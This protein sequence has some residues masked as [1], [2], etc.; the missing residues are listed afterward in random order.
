MRYV[1]ISATLLLAA[2]GTSSRTRGDKPVSESAKAPEPGSKAAAAEKP[3][4]P[5]APAGEDVTAQM[6][7]LNSSEHAGPP[8]KFRKGHVTPKKAPVTKKTKYGFEIRFASGAPVTTPAVYRGK[9][10]T[11]GGFNSKEFHAF[12]ASTGKSAWSISLDDDGPSSAA[13]EDGLC[14]FN[15]ES[16]T[17]FVVD[18]ETGK[19]QWSVWL[20]DPL[21]GSPTIDNGRV[22]TSYPAQ[23]RTAK[24]AGGKAA[25]PN[26]THAM[27]A[28]DLK[29]GKILWQ[30]WLDSGVMSA[31]VA[32]GKFVYVS[33]FGGTL[34]K[35]DQA[36][37]EIS[38]AIKARAT[39]APVIQF[40]ADGLESMYFTRRGEADGESDGAEEMIMRTDHNHPKTKFKAARKKAKY[41]DK[42]VQEKSTYQDEA[43]ASDS[44]NGFGGAAPAAANPAAA[45]DNIGQ[46][47]VSSMQAFQ[48]SRI[49]HMGDRNV[50][51]MGDEV[52]A[53][54]AETGEKL[55]SF[56]LS[57]DMTRSGGSLGT[58]PLAAGNSV[59][60]ATLD[61]EVKRLDPATGKVSG[62]WKIAGRVRAQP[63]VHDGWIYVG[64]EDGRLVAIDTGDRKVTGWA[65]WGGNAQRSGV[66]PTTKP[67]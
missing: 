17:L 8:T 20:G 33:T 22:F 56:K 55:W 59:V 26:A 32:S 61:G 60:F 66:G 6:Q 15:T 4:E 24:N 13:C 37:G 5:S 49:L 9:V 63:V 28:F 45:Y 10:Y 48:G 34:V 52:I 46:G 27:A 18:A 14:A 1:T 51:T 19:Q 40:A 38:Y 29:T 57:G 58:A 23:G 64:T 35:F 2:C 3:G 30:K 65:M 47:R 25:P 11:S 16:C 39:S 43:E 50:N 31:P 12:V 42:G 54:S 53:T 44:G 62:A 7:A 36:S 21:T 41:L 67:R